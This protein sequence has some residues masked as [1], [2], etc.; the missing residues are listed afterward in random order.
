MSQTEIQAPEELSLSGFPHMDDSTLENVRRVLGLSMSPAELRA[1]RT[2]YRNSL[3]RNPQIE[4][5]V[6]LDRMI[7][8]E[9]CAPH[10]LC[11]AEMKT[12]SP[13]IAEVFADLMKHR[14]EVVSELDRPGSIL[15]LAT[16]MET[17]LSADRRQ[18]PLSDIAVRFASHRN[19]QLACE[20][21]TVT[22]STGNTDSDISIGVKPSQTASNVGAVKAGDY[23]Y[24][25]LDT[26]NAEK[27]FEQTL[28]EYLS[29]PVVKQAAK[30]IHLVKNIGILRALMQVYDGLLLNTPSLMT[31]ADSA[32]P[33]LAEPVLGALLTVSPAASADMLLWAQDMGLHIIRAATV[34]TGGEIRIPTKNGTQLT[35]HTVFLRS[36]TLPRAYSVT[37]VPPTAEHPEITLTRIGSC[38]LKGRKH[39]VVKTDASG[40]EPFA[41]ALFGVLYALLYCAA[42]GISPTDVGLACRLTLP[43]PSPTRMGEALS[44]VLGLYRMQAEFELFGNAPTIEPGT[45]DHPTLSVAAIAPLP[46]RPV[47]ST[48]VGGGSRIFYLEPLYTADGIPDFSDL[49]KMLGYIQKLNRDGHVLSAR[50]TS[51]DLLSDLEKMSRDTTVEYVRSEPLASRFGGLLVETDIELQGIL[52]GKTESA[53]APIAESAPEEAPAEDVP[54]AES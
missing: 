5:L 10:H 3:R 38:T 8:A 45:E 50:P 17:Y 49:K 35:L 14:R 9:S 13:L 48:A 36:L 1:C 37:V 4:E 19:L 12:E 18:H 11:V 51:R 7:A 47:P 41:A 22:A 2:Y 40:D 26:K 27:G 25:L 39:A 46:E 53:P 16:V 52:V 33:E 54:V 43:R 44:M 34:T 42:A 28:T 21:Y 29:K 20:G 32:L 31:R 15:E 6:L 23:V 30:R 24:A